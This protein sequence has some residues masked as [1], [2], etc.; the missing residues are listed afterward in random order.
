MLV[1]PQLATGALCQFPLR[2]SRRSRTVT[3]RAADGSTIKLADPAAEIT[4]WQLE[5]AGLSDVEAAS[6]Q[7]FFAS[8]EGTLIGFTFLDPAGNLLASTEKLDGEVWQRDPLLTVTPGAGLWHLTNSGG[9]GQA[10]AQTLGVP[11]EYQYCVSA[12]VRASAGCSVGLIIGEQTVQ[13]PV[14]EWWTRAIATG[15]GAPDADSM[16]FGIEVPAGTS[17][18]VYGVQVEPQVGA[19]AYKSS[20]AGGVYPDSHLASDE[21]KMICTGVNR[22]SCR[23]HV[24]HANHI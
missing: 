19:S 8:V 16:R 9:A 14:G 10:V 18:E 20:T 17:I 4:E 6:L 22:N 13:Q 2:K 1:Y 24:I 21:M 15:T 7:G 5:Y 11:G 3:N 23:V 12:Y